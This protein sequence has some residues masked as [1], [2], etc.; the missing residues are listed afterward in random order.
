MNDDDL[1]EAVALYLYYA[2]GN[3]LVIRRK[4]RESV[5]LL[6]NESETSAEAQTLGERLMVWG[7]LNP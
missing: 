7:I 1:L 4:A 6:G 3:N 2:R 5:G